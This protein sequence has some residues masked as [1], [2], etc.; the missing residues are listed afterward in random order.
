MLS[1]EEALEQ[2][3]QALDGP[4]P[5][6]KQEELEAHLAACPACRDDYQA[7]L[8]ME[9]ALEEMGETPAPPELSARVM[10]Q[11]RTESRRPIPLWRKNQWRSFAGLAACAVLCLGLYYGSGL[12]GGQNV[13][14]ESTAASQSSGGEEISPATRDVSQAQEDTQAGGD[15]SAGASQ[16][17]SQADG[18]VTEPSQAPA[19]QDSLPEENRGT[20]Q[21]SVLDQEGTAAAGEPQSQEKNVQESASYAAAGETEAAE[22]QMPE[23]DAAGQTAPEEESDMPSVNAALAA[24]PWGSGTALVLSDLPQEAQELVQEGDWVTEEDGTRW[25]AVTEEELEDIQAALAQLGVEAPL[26]EKPWSQP[27]ALVLLPGETPAPG[28]QEAPE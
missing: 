4:L 24:P 26:P 3:S 2:M 16:D 18:A 27:Y 22:T 23:P 5:L 10:A 11:V 7:L 21:R 9:R 15:T 1:C 28:A 14:L 8:Q 19:S 17:A 12:G 6:E 25:R 13:T 20:E